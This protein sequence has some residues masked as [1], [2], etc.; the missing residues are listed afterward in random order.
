MQKA[1]A[2]VG[3]FFLP[4][5]AVVLLVLNGRRQLVGADNNRPW[6]VVALL[7]VLCFFTWMAMEK[8]GVI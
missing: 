5:L 2:V 3:A 6:T 1:Y 4:L 7:G 8:I